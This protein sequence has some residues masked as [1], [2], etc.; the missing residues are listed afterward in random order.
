MLSD[1]PLGNSFN[2]FIYK[3]CYKISNHYKLQ[4]KQ[5]KT[6]T[7]RKIKIYSTKDGSVVSL[8]EFYIRAHKLVYG[9]KVFSCLETKIYTAHKL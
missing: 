3:F 4:T 1:D 9:P 5:K 7:N 6:T 8:N 2:I